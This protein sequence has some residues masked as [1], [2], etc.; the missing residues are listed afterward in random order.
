MKRRG[1]SRRKNE[2]W[3]VGRA[4]VSFVAC[5]Q[6]VEGWEKMRTRTIEA[7]SGRCRWQRG[8]KGSKESWKN[9]WRLSS[10]HASHQRISLRLSN[11][12]ATP[13]DIWEVCK[14]I[15][16]Q[17]TDRNECLNN[18]HFRKLPATPNLHSSNYADEKSWGMHGVSEEA[19]NFSIRA[20]QM[21]FRVPFDW[22]KRQM[23]WKSSASCYKE[24]ICL[25]SPF[26]PSVC[27]RLAVSDLVNTSSEYQHDVSRTCT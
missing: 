4:K 20:L 6:Q 21:G 23:S 27:N 7:A 17:N 8:K 11:T 12:I 3:G 22:A 14:I 1:Q 5:E 15:L 13:L 16:E 18:I 9:C 24:I 19:F 2:Q 25:L 26:P 10:H